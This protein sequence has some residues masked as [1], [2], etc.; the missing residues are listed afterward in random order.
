MKKKAE[1]FKEELETFGQRLKKVRQI[2]GMNQK[3]FAQ[4]VSLTPQVM[5]SYEKGTSKPGFELFYNALRQFDVNPIYLLT[6]EGDMLTTGPAGQAG[7]EEDSAAALLEGVTIDVNDKEF[8]QY[9]FN[10]S[11]V[12][13]QTLS[14]FKKQMV[15]EKELIQE[16]LKK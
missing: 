13:F 16:D 9:Y 1:G 10:S 2:L 4:H 7:Q 15:E 8:L 11:I 6:G 3:V 5:G 12:R 14:N